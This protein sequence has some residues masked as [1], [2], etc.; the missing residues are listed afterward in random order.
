MIF[1]EESSVNNIQ[2]EFLFVGAIYKNASLLVDYGYYIRPQYDFSDDA[3]RFFY[4]HAMIIF[5]TRSQ[6]LSKVNVIP[7]MSED[8]E[9]FITFKRF[10]GYKTIEGWMSMASENDVKNYVD[11]LKKYSLLREYQRNGFNVDRVIKHKKFDTFDANQIYRL[12]RSKADRIKTVVMPENDAQI[13]NSHVQETIMDCLAQPDQGYPYPFEEWTEMFRGARHGIM[14]LLG[15]LSN[16]GKSRI[17]CKLVA[18]NALVNRE[19]VLV[20]LNEMNVVEFRYALI[21]TV[22]NNPEFEALHGIHLRKREREIT[23]GIYHDNNG[24]VIERKK[25][26]NG[27]F[28]EPVEDF[29]A[30]LQRDSDEFNKVQQIAK[31]I[32]EESVGRIVVKDIQ[33]DYSE[34]AVRFEIRK[35]VLTDKIKFVAYDTLKPEKSSIG[36]WDDFKRT[37]TVLSELAKELRIN[38]TA[39]FQLTDDAALLDPLDLTTNQIASSKQI[40]H[41]ADEMVVFAEV[42]KENFSKYHYQNKDPEWG[43]IGALT[44]L[45]NKKRYYIC[46]TLKNRAGNKLKLLFSLDL[47]LN[48]WFCDGTVSRKK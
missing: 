21:T 24:N 34:D 33:S 46:N 13:L 3:T 7:Y 44:N 6:E 32:D 15:M 8:S 45:S 4:E 18:Y 35:A 28:V 37:A 16:A 12:I 39:T 11:I 20:L 26:S 17:L 14:L 48:T 1:I 42:K 41:V 2:I 29:V 30:R 31:W 5:Q 19:N 22:I 40:M 47:D 43:E 36:Q 25:D 23:L 38:L 9:R 10:G 27:R